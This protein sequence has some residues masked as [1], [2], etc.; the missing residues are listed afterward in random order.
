[1][2][3]DRLKDFVYDQNAGTGTYVYVIDAGVAYSV[4]SSI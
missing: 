2:K 1:M 3:N 4:V